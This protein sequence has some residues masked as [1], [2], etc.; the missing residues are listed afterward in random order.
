MAKDEQG[1]ATQRRRDELV[2]AAAEIFHRKG[3][4][5]TSM[6][7][8]A[9]AVGMLK[10]SL[11]YY[12]D[13]KEDLLFAVIEKA[14]RLGSDGLALSAAEGGDALTQLRRTVIIHMRNNLEHLEEIGVFFQD[15]RSLSPERRGT[16]VAERDSYERFFRGLI[17][18]G[19]QEGTIDPKVDPKLA[20][21][22]LLGM[23]NWVYQWY[24]PD[25]P[26]PSE[27]IAEAFAEIA[28]AGIAAPPTGSD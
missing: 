11:Y 22:A 27:E 20:T 13:T 7:E 14:H 6:Q 16:I 9:E 24:R 2:V 3:Y 26:R 17:E 1:T 25:G 12:I 18:Q 5:A 4:D 15:F 8:I 10:G 23:I 21:K 28:L 19:Q